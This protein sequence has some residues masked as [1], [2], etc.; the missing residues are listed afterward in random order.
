MPKWALISIAGAISDQ[1]L[2]AIMT[3]AAKPSITFAIFYQDF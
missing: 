2:A 3:P 1:K